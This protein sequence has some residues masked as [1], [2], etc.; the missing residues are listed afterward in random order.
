MSSSV[1]DRAFDVRSISSD[2][3]PGR[4]AS[5]FAVSGTWLVLTDTNLNPAWLSS[6]PAKKNFRIQIL[7]RRLAHEL[8]T[9]I[10]T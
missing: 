2:V 1:I 5:A 3:S 8:K 7:S 4:A 9:C 10:T 6:G